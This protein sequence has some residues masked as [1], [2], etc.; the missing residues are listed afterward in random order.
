M[1][2]LT[3]LFCIMMLTVSAWGADGLDSRQESIV[4]VASATGRGDLEALRPALAAALDSGLTVSEIREVIVH[5]YAYCGFPRALRGLQTFM[6]VLDERKAAGI[7]DNPGRDAAPVTGDGRTRYE[8]GR[9][10][11]AEI[12]G[13]PADAP[14]AGYAV[15]APVIEQFLKEHLFAD[16]F[17]RD[18]LSYADR[19]LATI[20]V[21]AALGPSVEPMLRGHLGICR[22]LGYS[23]AQLDA[24]LAIA[25]PD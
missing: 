2:L 13:V 22:N 19:E 17:E 10:I 1:R 3:A 12:S 8:R 18:V 23:D 21:I 4:R 7:A 16:L 5:T 20:S 14:K 24:A 6:S 9:D 25:A 11:L 15:F